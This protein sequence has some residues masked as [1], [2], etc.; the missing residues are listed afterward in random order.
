MVGAFM[1]FAAAGYLIRWS[2][3]EGLIKTIIT[4]MHELGMGLILLIFFYQLVKILIK[5]GDAGGQNF[6][7]LVS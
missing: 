4:Y 7:L 6:G 3:E 2:F 1:W 5:K